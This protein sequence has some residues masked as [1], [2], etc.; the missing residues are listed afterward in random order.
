MTV[1]I[2]ILRVLIIDGMQKVTVKSLWLICSPKHLED[3]RRAWGI[4]PHILNLS[5]KWGRWSISH[6]GRFIPEKIYLGTLCIKG[7]MCFC[8]CLDAFLNWKLCPCRASNTYFPA[9][10][11]V[12]YLLTPAELSWLSFTPQIMESCCIFGKDLHTSRL[13]I[14][15]MRV[16]IFVTGLSILRSQERLNCVCLCFVYICV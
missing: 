7:W 9:I 4:A 2:T 15:K 10:H 13:F 6:L 3:V 8:A 1:T 11:P 5:S 12:T 16:P 14:P